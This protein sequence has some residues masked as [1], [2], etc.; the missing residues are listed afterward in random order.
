[1]LVLGIIS[2]LFL[3]I[4]MGLMVYVGFL[5][6]SIAE[7]ISA[8]SSVEL[9]V[10]SSVPF[11]VAIGLIGGSLSL[12]SIYLLGGTI[13][14]YLTPRCEISISPLTSTRK[15]LLVGSIFLPLICIGGS[16]ILSFRIGFI[17]G[18]I[19]EIP[20]LILAILY[21]GGWG[22][23]RGRGWARI[24]EFKDDSELISMVDA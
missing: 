7:E 5:I 3:G 18:W 4:G 10:I 15:W 8:A 22:I 11:A 24:A 19:V 17:L 14:Y 2:I 21:I 13:G 23:M 20:A 16:L 9:F 12:G 1:M 6:Q